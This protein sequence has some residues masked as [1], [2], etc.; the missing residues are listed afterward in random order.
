MSN[1]ELHEIPDSGAVFTFGKSRFADNIP[2]HFFVRKDPIVDISCGDE[3]TVVICQNGRAFSF[4][5]NG[6][7]ELGL[8]NRMAVARPSCVKSLKPKKCIHVA[9]GRAHSLFLSDTGKVYACGNN[10]EGQLG[11]GDVL[12]RDIPEEI[13]SLNS[14]KQLSAGSCHSAALT[15]SGQ[16]FVWGSNKEGQLGINT[17]QSSAS[18][19]IPKLLD[20]DTRIIQIACG[21]YHTLLLTEEGRILSFGEGDFGKLGVGDEI[22]RSVPTFIK[23]FDLLKFISAGGNHSAAI[24]LKGKLLVWGSNSR[25]QLGLNQPTYIVHPSLCTCL[26]DSAVSYVSCGENHTAV[27]TEKGVLYTFGDNAHGK[28]CLEKVEGSSIEYSTVP[29]KVTKLENFIIKKV[30]CGGCHTMVLGASSPDTQLRHTTNGM[31]KDIVIESKLNEVIDTDSLASSR[32]SSTKATS[33]APIP[34]YI[35]T[36]TNI[37]LPPPSSTPTPQNPTVNLDPSESVADPITTTLLKTPEIPE[38]I[39]ELFDENN[40][41]E[42]R[43]EAEVEK[44]EV[45]AE[46][47]ESC[48]EN[49]VSV[50]RSSF[51]EKQLPAC[52]Y[53]CQTINS[54]CNEKGKRILSDNS[55]SDKVNNNKNKKKSVS[56]QCEQDG[57]SNRQVDRFLSW[58]RKQK[59][60]MNIVSEQIQYAKV[61][62]A[63]LFEHYEHFAAN[64]DYPSNTTD[65]SADSQDVC[66]MNIERN[67]LFYN[68]APHIH[69]ILI[70]KGNSVQ[71]HNLLEKKPELFWQN[72]DLRISEV[73]ASKPNTDI[74]PDYMNSKSG[75]IGYDDFGAQG[76][77]P[78]LVRYQKIIEWEKRNKEE[79]ID[80]VR[81]EG[82]QEEVSDKHVSQSGEKTVQQT[83]KVKNY[84]II[85]K[86]PQSRHNSRNAG[87]NEMSKTQ[88]TR[89]KTKICVLL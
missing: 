72:V 22:R 88:S 8:G 62:L 35:R 29:L 70:C 36:S 26:E 31:R 78:Q 79:M 60:D 64:I 55:C 57:G 10:D 25:G 86:D 21:Y 19:N 59:E 48:G 89:E 7:G 2:S 82:D 77:G 37:S 73:N 65:I 18:I 24:T 43:E 17:D 13:A 63:Y 6:W 67:E 74:N 68:M 45:P 30:E 49:N 20:L 4:G 40:S 46:R 66:S 76:D 3:H 54:K 16:V 28:L 14:V 69:N 50:N 33:L 11:L 81:T 32:S 1:E 80:V 51:D 58:Y 9:C 12:L 75:N 34:K 52:L 47:I 42:N 71:N 23:S 38:K 39:D 87:R 53:P 61:K 85:K 5:R 15:I 41:Q 83:N 44:D 56:T 27:V 84:L